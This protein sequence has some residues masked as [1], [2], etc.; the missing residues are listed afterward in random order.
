MVA[1]SSLLLAILG[2]IGCSE[3]HGGEGCMLV[4]EEQTTCPSYEHV[5]TDQL[6]INGECG[7]DLEIEEVN[8]RGKRTAIGEL[9]Q[10][11]ACCYPVTIVDHR[12]NQQCAIGRP[13]FENGEAVTA[14]L[15]ADASELLP[16]DAARAAAWARAGA[17]EHASVAAFARLALELMAVG[18]PTEL[19]RDVHRAAEEEV[20]HAESAWE[21]AREFGGGR[22][23]AGP[24]P[25]A[26]PLS[27]NVTLVE[28]ARA[29]ARDG[30]L[31]ET[32]GAHLVQAAAAL[33]TEPSVKTALEAIA[34][35]E[36]RHAV[37]SYRIVAWALGAGGEAV[38]TAVREIFAS[39]WPEPEIGELALR[40]N[41]APEELRRAAAEGVASVLRPATLALLAA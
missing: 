15:R 32:L 19:L 21:L 37:L 17:E 29:A 5:S 13:Y 6:F 11:P 23:E 3:S 9:P 8:G 30:C 22:F 14:P 7:D 18:A 28:L 40:A 34:V 10:T 24:F 16:V 31:A 35:E 39:P 20:G 33:A 4:P 36:S 41:V 38:K 25:F 27:V 1:R 12:P 26:G 2:A